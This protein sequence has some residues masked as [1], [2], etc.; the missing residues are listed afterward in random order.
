MVV[1]YTFYIADMRYNEHKS[2]YTRTSMN[3]QNKQA[4][5]KEA[6]K[7]KKQSPILDDAAKSRLNEHNLQVKYGHLAEKPPEHPYKV[8]FTIEPNLSQIEKITKFYEK[9]ASELDYMKARWYKLPEVDENGKII[10]LLFENIADLD[11]FQQ[12]LNHAGLTENDSKID[13]E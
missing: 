5:I 1:F 9:F 6:D 2:N 10:T 4:N 13:V 3:R 12:R 11:Q 7:G 8:S